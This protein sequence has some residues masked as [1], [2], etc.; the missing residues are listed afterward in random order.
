MLSDSLPVMGYHRLPYIIFAG[1]IGFVCLFLLS[2]LDVGV[3]IMVVLLFGVN[4]SVASPGKKCCAHV[5]CA[6]IDDFLDVMVDGLIAERARDYPKFAT[7]LQSLCWGCMS[8]C[9]IV[10]Y[11]SSGYMVTTYGSITM[12]RVLIVTPLVIMTGGLFNWFGDSNKHEETSIGEHATVGTCC[13]GCMT[14]DKSF[15]SNHQ[16]LFFIGT[17]IPFMALLLS[18]IVMIFQ[19][20][21]IRLITVTMVFV[22]VGSSFFLVARQANLPEVANAGLFIFLSNAITP[23]IETALFYWYTDAPEGPQFTPQFVGYISGIAFAAM[24]L[25]ILIY[26]RYL[27]AWP[28]RSI[29]A[30]TMAFL[31]VMN[32]I[33]VVLVKRWN[34]SVGIPDE[35]MILGDSALSPMARRFYIMPLYILAAKVLRL[36]CTYK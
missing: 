8:I 3:V 35:I 27:S 9:A 18:A 33:D 30:C 36:A 13:G 26:N 34:L 25:G 6:L 11:L 32:L 22:L 12:F 19:E 23:D 21:E 17:F 16:N 7:D 14:Y 15:V 2:N 28:Y 29:F 31:A 1:M 24:F 10:G 4:L 5:N 20:W